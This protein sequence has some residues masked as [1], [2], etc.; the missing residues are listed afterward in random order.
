MFTLHYKEN[1][2]TL[3]LSFK[4]MFEDYSKTL[5][6]IKIILAYLIK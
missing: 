2:L 5:L 4:K 6:E 3:G 1:I